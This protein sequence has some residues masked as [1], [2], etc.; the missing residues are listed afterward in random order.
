MGDV[1]RGQCLTHGRELR[2]LLFLCVDCGFL[3]S[4]ACGVLGEMLSV[5][6]ISACQVSSLRDFIDLR[7]CLWL[8]N[9]SIV[10]PHKTAWTLN[11]AVM[12]Q[13]ERKS[14]LIP[15]APLQYTRWQ[16][17]AKHNHH[18]VDQKSIENKE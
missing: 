13:Q 10:E 4:D 2:S 7:G 5:Q 12:H 3:V 16:L 1:L 9:M 14:L 11:S 6:S 8:F 15:Q 18:L 17:S